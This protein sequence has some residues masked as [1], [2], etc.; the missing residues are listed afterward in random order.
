MQTFLLIIKILPWVL[1]LGG[2]VFGLI[3]RFRNKKLSEKIKYKDDAIKH[4]KN[5]ILDQGEDLEKKS[6]Q[7]SELMEINKKYEKKKKTIKNS[8]SATD[9]MASKR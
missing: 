7:I 9:S 4:L 6:K 8:K 1:S 3:S 2:G 5:I